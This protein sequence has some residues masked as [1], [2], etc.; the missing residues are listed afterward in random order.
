MRRYAFLSFSGLLLLFGAFLAWET[1]NV[2]YSELNDSRNIAISVYTILIS[3]L[4]GIPVL[5]YVKEYPDF[6]FC[7]ASFFVFISMSVT[8][9]LIFLPKVSAF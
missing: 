6:T 9:A 8:I 7:I 3:S 5:I 4:V 1:R 2:S